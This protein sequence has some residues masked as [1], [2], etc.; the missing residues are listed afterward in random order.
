MAPDLILEIEQ[1]TSFADGTDF[2]ASGAYERLL[3]RVRLATDPDAPENRSVIDLD[4]APRNSVGQVEFDADLC[5]LRPARLER[6]NGRALFDFGNRGNKRALAMF[7]DAPDN[8]DPQ[9]R[10]DAGTGFL[11][12]R[13]YSIV[14]VAWEGDILPGDDRM[15]VRLP[16]ISQEGEQ[17]SG[18]VR[19]VFIADCPGTFC[20]R[21]SGFNSARGYATA[22]RDT[23]KAALTRRQY[24]ESDPV[25]VS[26]ADWQFARLDASTPHAE[27]GQSAESAV[28]PSDEHIY[29][30]GGF[31]PGWIYELVY[32]AVD[33]LVMGLGYVAVRDLVAFLKYEDRDSAGTENP[34]RD[35]EKRLEKVY[36]FGRSQ[37]GR[38]IR[39]FVYQ[40][41]NSDGQKRRVFDGAF[42]HVAGAGRICNNHRW[43]QPVRLA[44]Y[45]HEDRYS[46]SDR[47]P[48]A[49][50]A[51]E[52]HLTGQRDG[53][54]KRSDTDP[55][56][57]H[58][59]TSGEMWHRH[60]S[61]VHTDTRGNDLEPG[62][63]VRIY[64]WSSSQHL[65]RRIGEIMVTDFSQ[66]LVNDAVA[67]TPLFRALLD[68]L[69]RWATDG[70]PPP[71]SRVPLG[72]TG[73]LVAIEEW[74]LQ[75]PLIPSSVT[76]AQPNRLPVW[77]YGSDADRGY[78]S[79]DPPQQ[80][81]AEEYAVLIPAVDDD[82]NER[83]GIRMPLVRVPLGTAT[84]WNIR[85]RGSSPGAMACMWGSFIPFPVTR[86]ERLATGDPRASIEERYDGEED[87]LQQLTRATHD[88]ADEGFLLLDEDLESVQNWARQVWR[89]VTV[90]ST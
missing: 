55:F 38:V 23:R 32:T 11:M 21:L 83:A 90:P 13:G 24:T 69:D 43:S 48:F 59:Q 54:L 57:I 33:P 9:R 52:D 35:S 15:T 16:V 75:F 4:L 86:A 39:D 30:P 17:I 25:G 7:N 88:L 47:F 80:V 50:T 14:W 18:Q 36:C 76:P 61:L 89:M 49:Y 8:N 78:I 29:L 1:R 6:G 71:A 84:G 79:I 67:T 65:P 87:F 46:Y 31:E 85:A 62:D 37:T 3:G 82:G 45:Q 28:V 64:L 51:T 60:G 70:T 5:I 53:L 58:T 19:R 10:S 81:A 44:S 34:L 20:L 2:G 72:S 42:C 22:S 74:R 73:E 41:F 40:G 12:R 66:H 27:S 68:H 63:N 77:D 56:W 26:A